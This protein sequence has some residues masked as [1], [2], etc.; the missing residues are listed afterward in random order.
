[1]KAFQILKNQNSKGDLAKAVLLYQ[2]AL[3]HYANESNWAVKADASSIIWIGDDDPTYVA[4]VVLGLCQPKTPT[5][6]VREPDTRLLNNRKIATD[7]PIT[8]I[9]DKESTDA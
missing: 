1:M 9:V 8:R 3:H 4:K 6:I 5:K 7:V 2:R